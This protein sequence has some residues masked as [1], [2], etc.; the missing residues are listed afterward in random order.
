MLDDGLKS[1]NISFENV[2]NCSADILFGSECGEGSISYLI[3]DDEI[4]LHAIKYYYRHNDYYLYMGC[5]GH[6]FAHYYSA[7]ENVGHASATLPTKSEN[8]FAMQRLLVKK[9]FCEGALA[10]GVQ[11]SLLLHRSCSDSS[12]FVQYEFLSII[13]R[14]WSAHFCNSGRDMSSMRENVADI[15]KIQLSLDLLKLLNS[16]GYDYL[17]SEIRATVEVAR[18]DQHSDILEIYVDDIEKALHRHVDTTNQYISLILEDAKNK[19]NHVV[20]NSHEYVLFTG[21]LCIAWMWLKQGIASRDF[22]TKTTASESEKRFHLGK[23]STLDYF[24][25]YELVKTISQSQFL[26]KNPQILDFAETDWIYDS[27]AATHD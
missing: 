3:G 17:Q 9:A 15:E 22:L 5:I 23:I 11:T 21:H 14:I 18:A 13:L 4:T 7:L 2:T 1:N 12:Y 20:I 6:A 10:L 26:L 24:C 25:N 27:R 19:K 8:R 16:G